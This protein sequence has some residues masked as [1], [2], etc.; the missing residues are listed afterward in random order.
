[1]SNS[2]RVTLS[3]TEESKRC[4][5]IMAERKHMTQSELVREAIKEYEVNHPDTI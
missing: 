3:F 5:H 1:M 2:I 4:L